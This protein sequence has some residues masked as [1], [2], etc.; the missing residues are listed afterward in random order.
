VPRPAD[1]GKERGPEAVGARI[2]KL[3]E[4][5]GLSISE[6]AE[7]ADVSKSYLWELEKGETD[8]R[9]SGETLYKISRVLGTSMSQLLGHR[10]LIDGPQQIPASL[11]QF[12]K[13]ERLGARDIQMLA[14]INFR[15]QQPERAEDWEFLWR[16]IQRSV[17]SRTRRPRR[18][19]SSG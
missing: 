4:R 14:G 18:P 1:K 5:A 13:R 2:K 11:R 17:P 12:A 19:A 16:A 8:V 6:L 15:G 10:V 9:P 3:R 7:R